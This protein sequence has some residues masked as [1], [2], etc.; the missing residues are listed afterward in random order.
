MRLQIREVKHIPIKQGETK[1]FS[2]IPQKED[3]KLKGLLFTSGAK[4]SLSFKN[5]A[6]LKFNQYQFLNTPT[7]S[8]D[9]RII[10]MDE[11]ITGIIKGLVNVPHNTPVPNGVSIYFI[12]EQ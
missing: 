12:V 6:D 3:R 4:L 1:V 11:D 5:G 9:S 8:P 7:I 10:H 2:F